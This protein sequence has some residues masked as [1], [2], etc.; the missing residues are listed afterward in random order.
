MTHHPPELL[1]RFTF[2]VLDE[3]HHAGSEVFSSIIHRLNDGHRVMALTATLRREDQRHMIIM[4]KLPVVYCLDLATAIK[5]GLVAPVEVIPVGVDMSDGERREYSEIERRIND[6][7]SALRIVDDAG[8]RMRL[9][10]QLKKYINRRRML[11]SRLE[12]K[13]QAVYNI[14]LRHPNERILIFSENIESIEAL[15]RYLLERG[16]RAETYHSNK[17][18]HVRDLIFR[19]WGLDFN[20]LLSCRALDEGID[21]PECGIAVMIA[22]GMSVRQLVQRKGR[23]MR[24]REGKVA[25]LYIIYARGSIESKIPMKVKAI[26]SGIVR[27]Y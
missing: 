11:L 13:R 16:V 21:V 22:S 1:D 7:K 3:V 20:V 17:P 14:A 4:S 5:Q 25:K 9:E 15:K 12:A 6:I 18:E 26:L 10:R 19:R 8:E 24:P 27:L 23:I 2:I